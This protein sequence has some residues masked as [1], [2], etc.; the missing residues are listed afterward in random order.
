MSIDQEIKNL[1]NSEKDSFILE[2]KNVL[3]DKSN[4]LESKNNSNYLD[5]KKRDDIF[6]DGLDD[7]ENSKN[8][9]VLENKESNKENLNLENLNIDESK[10]ENV[11]FDDKNLLL[12]NQVLGFEKEKI[13]DKIRKNSRKNEELGKS[14]Q[15]ENELS[16]FF[17]QKLDIENECFPNIHSKNEDLHEYSSFFRNFEKKEP[18]NDEKKYSNTD[19]II[20]NETI[21]NNNN[22]EIKEDLNLNSIKNKKSES[23]LL[24]YKKI[25]EELDNLKEI[26]SRM[27]AVKG[28]IYQVV[29]KEVQRFKK[30]IYNKNFQE[31][32]VLKKKIN[33]L[34]E[35]CKLIRME[36]DKFKIVYLR[37]KERIKKK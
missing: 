32:E 21:K 8:V 17:N 37:L 30:E 19:N 14:F 23:I 34:E 4:R 25:Q 27:F 2:K 36:R 31:I 7:K 24:D 22:T 6:L 26:H 1:E 35:E 12:R 13:F 15:H 9:N 10:K 33:D 18:E 11:F 20:K 5:L 16:K 3:K 29:E 28:K